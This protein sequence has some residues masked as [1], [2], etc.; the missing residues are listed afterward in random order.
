MKMMKR[1]NL[2]RQVCLL[3]LICS[4]VFFFSCS[5]DDIANGG[6]GPVTGKQLSL[7][8]SMT[9]I[10]RAS[11]LDVGE[12][13]ANENQV[14]RLTVGIFSNN[15]DTVRTIQEFVAGGTNSLTVSSDKKTVT[16]TVAASSLTEGDKVLVAVNAPANEFA[17]VKS[18]TEF[19]GK[20]IDVNQALATPSSGTTS[21]EEATDNLPMYGEGS[22]SETDSKYSSSVSVLHQL[23]KI[24]VKEVN[25]NFDSS[26]PIYR[27][28]TFT[29]KVFFLINVPEDLAFSKA[30]WTGTQND[31][32]QGW[33]NDTS[34]TSKP[35]LAYL[36]SGSITGLTGSATG[37]QIIY[38]FNKFFYIMP[39]SDIKNNTQLVI[40]GLY[41][42]DGL[43]GNTY[44]PETVYYPVNINYNYDGTTVSPA[45]T[46][47][48]MKAVYPNRNYVCTIE[49]KTKGSPDPYTPIEPD[50]AKVQVGV[51]GFQ[52]VDHSTV[53]K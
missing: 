8:I 52:S 4:S 21:S 2:K 49:I 11:N 31:L 42:Q 38:T 25:V 41:D 16:A 19:S 13:D 5:S 22:V 15:G 36:N 14:N 43:S 30:A 35:Y 6:S 7:T 26:D 1:I 17:G 47:T 12:D 44:Q 34:L 20:T 9:P 53:F 10:S 24:T 29:P 39:N 50:A 51:N 18:V 28:A 32:Y 27:F 37:N 48:S 33:T 23:A 46:G 45:E 3:G 40:E